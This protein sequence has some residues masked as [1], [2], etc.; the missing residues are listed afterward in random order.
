MKKY[1]ITWEYT[2]TGV[3]T[4]EAENLDDA[5]DKAPDSV[6]DFGDPTQFK[7]IVQWNDGWDVKSV[8]EVDQQ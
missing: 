8:E 4:L 2:Q 3:S 1:R 5:K 6:S 7:Q